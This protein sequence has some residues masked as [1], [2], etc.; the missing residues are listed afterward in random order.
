MSLFSRRLVCGLIIAALLAGP[1]GP[2]L[3]AAEPAPDAP[4]AAAKPKI[5]M[6]I[7][8]DT[9][10]SMQG[11]INQARAHIWKIVNEFATAKLNGVQPTFE[12]ALYEYGKSSLDEK[13]GFIRLI[14]PL[15][16]DLDKVSEE[17]FKLET[18]GGDEYCGWVIQRAVDDLKWSDQARD[19]KCIFIAGNEPFTQGPVDFKKSCQAAA[20]KG[21][22]V[23]TIFCGPTEE[24]VRTQWLEG[25]KLADGSYVSIDQNEVVPAI[26]A[27]Q[28]K[29]LERLSADLNKTYLAYGS[30]KA[31]KEALDRQ[32]AQDANA[33][34]AA[35]GA[36]QARAKFKAG[37]FYSNARW[38]LLDAC[39]EG[40]VKLED[41]KDEE[42]PPELKA[43]K[44]AERKAFVE[45]KA[46]QRAELQAQIKALSDARDA[47]VAAELKKLRADSNGSLDK[48]IIE[49][50]RKQAEQKKFELGK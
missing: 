44:P 10:G 46:K 19:L 45:A 24:G 12:V 36:A 42:L 13:E 47:Y 5:Q 49:A 18:N 48:A 20:D 11:L 34:A 26:A 27:P 29:E 7:L 31:R 2:R 28:D 14:Q 21:I 23:S 4:P 8:L 43:L 6:A 9:S 39:R 50:A 35:P 38:D 1:W 25:S 32:I 41:L 33:A 40:V 16:N 22:T 3:S 30:E 37:G 15:T 17:L